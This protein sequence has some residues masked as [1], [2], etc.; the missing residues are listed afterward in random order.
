[1]GRKGKN[2]IRRNVSL[3]STS[4]RGRGRL[5]GLAMTLRLVPFFLFLVVVLGLSVRGLAGNPTPKDLNT[6]AWKDQ[7]PLELSPERGRFSLLYSLAENRSFQLS[8]DLARFAA[9]D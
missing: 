1:M 8:V 5:R 2:I 3:K 6:L 4:P 9:P 7:G